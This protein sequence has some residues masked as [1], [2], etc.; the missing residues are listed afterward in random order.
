MRQQQ[1]LPPEHLRMLNYD[2]RIAVLNVFQPDEVDWNE[3]LAR[4]Q[5][6]PAKQEDGELR[7]GGGDDDGEADG[8]VAVVREEG[9]QKPEPRKQHDVDIN[10]H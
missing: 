6:A 8:A 3:I 2:N 1:D 7:D 10:D 5:P 4:F 9:H